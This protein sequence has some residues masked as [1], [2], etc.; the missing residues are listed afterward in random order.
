MGK[1]IASF[2]LLATLF[3]FFATPAKAHEFVVLYPTADAYTSSAS[4]NSAHGTGTRLWVEN[5]AVEGSQHT[6]LTFDLSQAGSDLCNYGAS[7]VGLIMLVDEVSNGGHQIYQAAS[8]SWTEAGLKWTN[9]PG[10]TGSSFY[11]TVSSQEDSVNDLTNFPVPTSIISNA[12]CTGLVSF[13]IVGG[14]D[15]AVAWSS[16][17]TTDKPYL[18]IVF[19]A[20]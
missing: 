12:G 9:E 11:T 2:V 14:S 6:Y 18:Q 17:E 5:D 1:I 13:E 8:T 3:S 4:P 19:N 10:P 15:N 16:R 7:S 20:H